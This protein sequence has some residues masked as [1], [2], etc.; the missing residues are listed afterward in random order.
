MLA[1]SQGIFAEFSLHLGKITGAEQ[2]NNKYIN[3]DLTQ[4]IFCSLWLGVI[5][6]FL[7]L[8]KFKPIS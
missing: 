4:Q 7:I 3:S 2:V 5:A 1:L 8:T 6:K